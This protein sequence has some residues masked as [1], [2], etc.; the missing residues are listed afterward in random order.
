[1][2]V[3]ICGARG[4]TPSPGAEFVRH[5]GHTSCVAITAPGEEV[6]RLVLDAGTGLQGLSR[7]L[8]GEAFRGTVSSA[9]CTGTTPTAS[10]FSRQA[11]GRTPRC[12]SCCPSRGHRPG[13]CWR[14]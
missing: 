3:S 10:R 14:E 7:F 11:T 5:G 9:T 4:S 6:P 1:M 12:R 2:Q 8:G 13:R